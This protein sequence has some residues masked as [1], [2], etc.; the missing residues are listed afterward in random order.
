M[1]ESL[2][3]AVY[4]TGLTLGIGWLLHVGRGIFVPIVLSILVVYVIDG[5]ARFTRLPASATSAGY[6]RYASPSLMS[7][8]LPM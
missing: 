2:R 6:V 3:T 5:L 8:S 4:A 7:S 1:N